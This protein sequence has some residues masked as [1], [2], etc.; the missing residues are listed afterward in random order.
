MRIKSIE[1]FIEYKYRI[2]IYLTLFIRNKDYS[3]EYS[4]IFLL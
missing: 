4:I 2:R 1:S 3:F